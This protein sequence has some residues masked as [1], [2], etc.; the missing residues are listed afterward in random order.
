[1]CAGAVIDVVDATVELFV[2]CFE[3]GT[4]FLYLFL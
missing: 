4:E 1:M 2:K 3:F